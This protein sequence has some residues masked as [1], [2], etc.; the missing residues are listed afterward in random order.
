[1]IWLI[2]YPAP[3]TDSL[4]SPEFREIIFTARQSDCEG[5]MIAGKMIHPFLPGCV[6]SCPQV[7]DI[8]KF[9]EEAWGRHF[10]VIKQF[11][12]GRRLVQ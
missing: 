12:L 1:M 8:E 7:R 5:L 2:H 4:G 3:V 9:V 6:Q 10:S 11:D